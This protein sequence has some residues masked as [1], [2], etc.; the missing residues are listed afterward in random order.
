MLVVPVYQEPGFNSFEEGALHIQTCHH[1]LGDH[2]EAVA[3]RKALLQ[4]VVPVQ[5]V[6]LQR[7]EGP[8]LHGQHAMQVGLYSTD[9]LACTAV[10]IGLYSTNKLACT[11]VGIGLYSSVV[12]ACTAV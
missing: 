6:P 7:H 4:P 2:V 10:G 3:H 5:G 11:A 8:S 12:L 9:K 1:S